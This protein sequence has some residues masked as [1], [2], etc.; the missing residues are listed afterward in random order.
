MTSL[1][2]RGESYNVVKLVFEKTLDEESH[3]T[4]KI[5]LYLLCEGMNLTPKVET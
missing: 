5:K 1:F 2:G 3:L 4:N